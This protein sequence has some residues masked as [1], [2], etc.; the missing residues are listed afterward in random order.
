MTGGT[1]CAWALVTSSSKAERTPNAFSISDKSSSDKGH[2]SATTLVLL[3]SVA[4]F[5]KHTKI[6]SM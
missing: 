1:P 2:F 6:L 4:N 3:M 5:A